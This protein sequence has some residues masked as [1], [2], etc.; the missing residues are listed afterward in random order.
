M[1]NKQTTYS[2]KQPDGIES[3]EEFNK[4]LEDEG[5]NHLRKVNSQ[6][7]NSELNRRRKEAEENGEL[8]IPPPGIEIPTLITKLNARK[9]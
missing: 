5:L 4:W 9:A 1:V 8:F 7:L 2:F 3:T 6:T